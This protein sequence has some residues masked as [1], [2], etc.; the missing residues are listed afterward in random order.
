MKMSTDPQFLDVHATSEPASEQ[1]IS[2]IAHVLFLDIVGFTKRL[3][4]VQRKILAELL[5]IVTNSA[6]FQHARSCD[7]L[8]TLPT[9]DGMALVFL[10]QHESSGPAASC[11][12]QI[13]EAITLYNKG[14]PETLR[15]DLRMGLHSGN[16]IRVDD[17]NGHPNV[18]GEAINTAQRVMDCGDARHILLSSYAK[19]LLPA[20]PDRTD[21]L[22]KLGKVRVKHNQPVE[23]FNLTYGTIGKR[24]IPR[25]ILRQKLRLPTFAIVL[26]TLLVFLFLGW[27][28]RETTTPSRPS[29]AILPFEPHPDNPKKTS[30]A[31]STGLT[32]QMMRTLRVYADLKPQTDVK[33]AVR[34]AKKETQSA[35]VDVVG[36]KLDV[37]YVLKGYADAQTEHEL[38]KF[39]NTNTDFLVDIHVELYEVGKPKA[40]RIM[41]YPGVQFKDLMMFPKRLA[42]DAATAM[43][44][45]V[46][47]NQDDDKLYGRDATAFWYYLQG[48]YW[49]DFRSSKDAR[50]EQAKKP[51]TKAT[52]IIRWP[53]RDWPT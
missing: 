15:F 53:T 37:R 49:W 46:Q 20:E 42:A 35:I 34:V 47:N 38:E 30:E 52:Q 22:T 1:P 21:R 11:A 50:P 27:Y 8:I 18:A 39:D 2:D 32:E 19:H 26:V 10:N 31:I 3:P 9:G 14:L 13:A 28:M 45:P 33:E 25:K 29:V 16:I 7:E 12:E 40:L 5:H 6:V 48:R 4:S 23:L 24:Q 17:I 41:D 51:Q 43:G 44:L 36:Q